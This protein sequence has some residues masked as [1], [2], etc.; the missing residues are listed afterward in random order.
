MNAG[1]GS[2]KEVLLLPEEQLAAAGG[3]MR[4]TAEACSQVIHPPGTGQCGQESGPKLAEFLADLCAAVAELRR[5]AELKDAQ[6][7]QI[8]DEFAA[9][10][11]C[12]AQKVTAKEQ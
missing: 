6:L 9:L 11:I 5:S 2:G 4:D 10:D 7:R 12:L 8:A 3:A 1:T